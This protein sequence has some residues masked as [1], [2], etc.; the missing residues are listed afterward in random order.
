MLRQPTP[1]RCCLGCCPTRPDVVRS[2]GDVVR[3]GGGVPRP[4]RPTDRGGGSDGDHRADRPGGAVPDLRGAVVDGQGPAVETDQGSAGVRSDRRAVVAQTPAGV[5]RGLC[6]RRSFTQTAEAVRPRGRVTERLRDKVASAIATSNRSVTDVAGRV[7]RVVAD[8]APGV[9]GGG[10]PVAAR[11]RTDRGAGDRRD[12]VPVGPLD[13]RRHHLETVGSVADQLRRLHPRPSRRAARPRARP[14]RRLRR[15]TGS[16]A[17]SDA[18]RREIEIVVIDPSA[19]Y[20]SGIRAALPGV[21]DRG[22]QVASRRA[23]QRRWSPRSGNASPATCSAA[24]APSAT[25]SGSTAACC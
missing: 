6:P 12:P 20:A 13:P 9:G 24:A 19:P 18:F 1:L 21:E 16:A 2:G 7:R 8:R 15:A 5:R 11:T 14:H 17:Q 22:R 4:Q 25:R 3:S 10:G 23:G